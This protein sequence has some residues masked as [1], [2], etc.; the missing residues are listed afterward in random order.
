VLSNLLGLI[1]PPRCA[2]CASPSPPAESL[3]A[4]CETALGAVLGSS[5]PV[6]GADAAW[7]A[8][9]YEGV[10]REVVS[11]LKFRARLPLA[12]RVA[13]ALAERAPAG[14]LDPLATIVPVPAAPARLRRRG[15]DAAE[16][17][18]VALARETGIPVALCL[19]RAQGRRQVG[20]PRGERLADPP[21]V[22]LVAPAPSRVLLVDD[23]VTTGAS[24]SACAR[25]LRGG[26]STWIAALTFARS[27]PPAGGLGATVFPA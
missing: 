4:H 22:H 24:L 11:A 21:R 8:A 2:V 15:F 25:A 7:S 9:A 13:R 17:T 23:V 10:A 20:R 19:R 12:R 1:A 14:L 27:R 6:P 5:S 3:C 18:A 16:A 26:G